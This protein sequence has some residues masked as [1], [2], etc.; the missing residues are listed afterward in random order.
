MQRRDL[1]PRVEA[2]FD[3]EGRVQLRARSFARSLGQLLAPVILACS[4]P[5]DLKALLQERRFYVFHFP[6]LP[7]PLRREVWEREIDSVFNARNGA[8]IN[9]L[10]NRFVFTGGQIRDAVRSVEG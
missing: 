3:A 7:F 10:A 2:F 5:C 9:A 4:R 6:A 1:P 8:D